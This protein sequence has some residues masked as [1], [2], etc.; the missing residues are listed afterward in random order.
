MAPSGIMDQPT[1]SNFGRDE[2][3]IDIMCWSVRLLRQEQPWQR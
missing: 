2:R 1:G 3:V